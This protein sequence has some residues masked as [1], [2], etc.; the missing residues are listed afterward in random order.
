[1]EA[2]SLENED[3]GLSRYLLRPSPGSAASRAHYCIL[4]AR[5]LVRHCI[6]GAR[7]LVRHCILW[8]FREVAPVF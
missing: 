7:F 2:L 4:G 1:M 8:K 6:L 3:G 5:F